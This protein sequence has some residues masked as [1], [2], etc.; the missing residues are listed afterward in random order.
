M[1]IDF[2]GVGAPKCGTTW[3]ADMLAAHPEIDFSKYKETNYFSSKT[4]IKFSKNRLHNDIEK[5]SEKKMKRLFSNN[6]PI[7]GEFS[8]YYLYDPIA[9]KAIKKNNPSIKIIVCLRN[10]IQAC[11]SWYDYCRNSFNPNQVKPT[12]DEDF[13][14]NEFYGNIYKYH[15]HLKTLFSIFD[16]SQ[17]LIIL[18]EEM[19]SDPKRVLKK[20]YTYLNV[21]NSFVPQKTFQRIY[22]TKKIRFKHLS[23]II[24]PTY[25]AMSAL[26]LRW[27]LERAHPITDAL[28]KKPTTRRELTTDQKKKVYTYF[29]NDIK[30]VEKLTG[31]DLS[32]WKI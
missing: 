21:D 11:Q 24:G 25:K 7:K 23:I 10:P 22:T 26:G 13:R 15:P 12:F 9:L 20:L 27:F 8:V 6:S 1:K 4:Y 32:S 14:T 29:Q 31:L 3:I 19:S 2:A 28:L 16:K 30:N 17:V 18:N 5:V